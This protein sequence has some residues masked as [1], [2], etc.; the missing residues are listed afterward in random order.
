MIESVIIKN[1]YLVIITLIHEE[2]LGVCDHEITQIM[3]FA[4]RDLVLTL[5]YFLQN[6][7][8]FLTVMSGL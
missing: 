4:E 1:S 5:N 2:R 8:K 6:I 7:F 3:Q